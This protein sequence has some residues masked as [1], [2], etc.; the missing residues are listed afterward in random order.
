MRSGHLHRAGVV[1]IVLAGALLGIAGLG[2][3]GR[4]AAVGW[5]DYQLGEFYDVA[6]IQDAAIRRAAKGVVFFG[7]A[8]GFFVSPEGHVLTNFHVA[9]TF[10]STGS[11]YVEW[12][13][14]GYRQRV[15]LSLVTYSERYDMALYKARGSGFPYIP[16][17]VSPGPR[18]GEDVFIVGH[19]NSRSQEVSFGRILATGH[20]IAGRPSVEYS[21][22]TWWGS[23][24]SP[25]CD[26]AGNAVALHWGWDAEGT[27]TGRL[28][29]V[30]LDLMAAA[31]PEMK[32]I[33]ERYG[34]GSS[35]GGAAGFAAR[36]TA[37]VASGG[38]SSSTNGASATSSPAPSTSTST[39][40]N[41]NAVGTLPVGGSAT[42][43]L[44]ASELRYLRLDLAARGD[45]TVTLSGPASADF[46]LAVWKWDQGTGRNTSAGASDG[47]TAAEAVT[48]R[49][50]SP[51]TYYVIVS[52]YRGSG[53]F[54]VSSAL[55]Q[56]GVAP[57]TGGSAASASG[58]LR[59]SGD[60]ALY[61]FTVDRQARVAVALD[62]PAGADFDLFIY[63]GQTVNAARLAAYSDSTS[64]DERVAFTAAAG[65][66]SILVYSHSGAG[67]FRVTLE[68]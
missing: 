7:N 51:G 29:G 41:A 49:S 54:R 63:R 47:A 13:D 60:W 50:A 10:G 37:T 4:A 27:S 55:A 46:D 12:T 62:G 9:Q 19:P 11:V 53:A 45:L 67:A 28:A 5:N 26:R 1:S 56:G 38:G 33:A 59:S 57:G 44:G 31:V 2:F 52:A 39:S 30:P 34:A 18:R 21:A 66:Y 16:V 8:T 25:V 24:G 23:S 64:G 22:Q 36:T 3:P 35:G 40:G 68:R 17:R 43:S 58:V 15:Q 14:A 32:Q 65:T 6:T 42:G 61:T 48:V 20:T